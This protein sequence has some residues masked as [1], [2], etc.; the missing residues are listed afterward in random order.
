MRQF[1]RLRNTRRFGMALALAVG[2][3]PVL[4]MKAGIAQDQPAIRLSVPEDWT[5]RHVIFSGPR[6]AAAAQRM[7]TDPRYLRQ[8]LRHN[9]PRARAAGA[10]ASRGRNTD[11]NSVFAGR[12]DGQG[13][14]SSAAALKPFSAPCAQEQLRSGLGDA[15][16]RGRD[17][18]ERDVPG[19]I[20]LRHQCSPEL[21][22]R[23][24]RLQHQPDRTRRSKASRTG[25][26]TASS[27]TG[28]VAVNGTT[29]TASPGTAAS[30]STT[31]NTNGVASGNTDHHHQLVRRT[32]R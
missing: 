16:R 18:R 31:I 23:F 21:R 19:E 13:L 10:D 27:M 3:F 29:L 22:Q 7:Q 15:A 4:A 17:G 24:R 30:Q 14:S 5:S 12:S 6:T 9:R 2:L 8:W 25:T 32:S 1:S 26:F 28:T 20:Q 11:V